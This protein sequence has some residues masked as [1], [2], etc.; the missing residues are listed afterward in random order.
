M[1]CQKSQNRIF[2]LG[3]RFRDNHRTWKVFPKEYLFFNCP[4]G[5]IGR[6]AG[7]KIQ[8]A[9]MFIRVQVP[10]WVQHV[11]P[12]Y[13]DWERKLSHSYEPSGW[14]EFRRRRF[15]ANINPDT[16]NGRKIEVVG[17][18]KDQNPLGIRIWNYIHDISK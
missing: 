4:G 9:V 8:W 11:N 3:R 15:I 10:S 14:Y 1:N 18:T 13:F 16:I 17:I 5:E 2:T 6:H 12:S 7:L